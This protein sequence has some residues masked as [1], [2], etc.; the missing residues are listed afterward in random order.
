M[1]ATMWTRQ[2]RLREG[3]SHTYPVNIVWFSEVTVD[4]IEDVESAV[5]PETRRHNLF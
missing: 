2:R 4:P 3:K 5:S 1:T